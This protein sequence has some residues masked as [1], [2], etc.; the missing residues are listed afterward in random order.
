MPSRV[1]SSELPINDSLDDIR[2]HLKQHHNL[3][4]EAPT[5][6]GKTTVV[7]LA[8]LD[9]PWLEGRKIIMLQPRRLAAKNAALRMASLMREPVG[10]TVGY[11][12]RLDSKISADTRIEVITE[13]ILLRMLRDDPSLTAVGLL[14]FDEFHERS[15]DADLGLTLALNARE[16]FEQ[17]APLRIMLMSATLGTAALEI[18]LNTHAIRSEGRM[19]AV[20]ERY[21]QA[22]KPRERIADRV[23]RAIE[24]AVAEHVDSSVLVFLPGQGEIRQVSSQLE[25]PPDVSI[26]PLYGELSLTEQQL[27]IEPSP[28]G[29]RK[30]VLAT[31]IAETS[32]TIDGVDIVI[33]SGLERKPL[34]DPN[35]GMSRLETVR[36]SQASS[37]Q[38]AGR[39]GRLR[40][41]TCYR[42]WSGAQQQQLKAQDE[43][44]IRSADLTSLV[45][46]LFAFGVYDPTELAWLTP[47]PPG[48]YQQAV[49]LLLELAALCR[50]DSGLRL[51]PHGSAMASISAHPRLAHM[52]IM[53]QSVG[54]SETA[55]HLAAV[56]SDRD[57]VGRESVDM[58]TRLEYLNGEG[59]CPSMFR[60]WQKRTLQLAAQFSRQS[61]SEVPR[62]L[63]RPT[64]EQ[65][66]GFLI[67][68]A[69]PD[70]IAR[71]RHSG[72]YQLANGRSSQFESPNALSSS[73]W[74]AV[75]EI[76]GMAGRKGDLIRS[77]APLDPTL[78]D[79]LLKDQISD[80]SVV[81]WDAKS[82]RF[83]AERRRNC[84]ALLL[85][86]ETLRDVSDEARTRKLIELTRDAELTNLPWS[87]Q[88]KD[89]LN[90]AELM[91][92]LE[93]DWPSFE[94]VQLLA[95]LEDWLAPYL[96]SV[97]KL[98]E[99][100]K[101]DLLA[102]I[103]S[104]IS[105][106]QQQRL[107]ANLP[108]R[109][110]A[111][112]GSLVKIDYSQ[113]PPVLPVKLQEMF[114]SEHTPSI[115]GGRVALVVHL[116][117]PAGRPLQVTQD[118][119]SFWRSSYDAVKKEMRGRYPKHPWPDD[120]ATAEPTRYTKHRRKS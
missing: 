29:R 34:F 17:D 49:D 79:T 75:A 115:A 65:L 100:K 23:T 76:G 106:E 4:L 24:N 12:M 35:T 16:T 87:D 2:A 5:G 84:G 30:V 63:P 59:A 53:G 9:E 112:S 62:R 10:K 38:R 25:L 116:L 36:I 94:A 13:G 98:G 32:L 61:S 77:A 73:K 54:A 6:A 82:G 47:P 114:G 81:D 21:G 19:F 119:P 89:F 70:R 40:P 74:L 8:L 71:Q 22:S 26:R 96:S 3:V 67:A 66:P 111:P 52:L 85:R 86:R 101:L 105:W 93:A 31:N 42:L 118:L 102:I 51:T 27:A 120:P 108:E 92:R 7:P 57:P 45:L 11:R 37:V 60:G 107:N 88:T 18:F 80:E 83:I 110:K 14:I 48:P 97:K 103:Q 44:E 1:Q 56:L 28:S 95:T 72:G 109:F 50:T 55:G 39:A 113:D 15:L 58:R 69:Y 104:R 99:L 43:P 46:Q 33:D 41:G 68:C 90:K 117:S 64:Q 91:S 78:F 20:E